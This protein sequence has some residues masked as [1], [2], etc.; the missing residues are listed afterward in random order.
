ML[1]GGNLPLGPLCYNR[2]TSRNLSYGQKA[3]REF[4]FKSS[5]FTSI[6]EQLALATS[7]LQAIKAVKLHVQIV[8]GSGIRLGT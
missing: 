5:L 2:M 7:L 6:T 1:E 4:K 8:L 3:K